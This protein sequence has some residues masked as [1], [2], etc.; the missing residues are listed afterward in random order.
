MSQPP[1]VSII[2]AMSAMLEQTLRDAQTYDNPYQARYTVDAVSVFARH[3][4]AIVNEDERLEAARP[5]LDRLIATGREASAAAPRICPECNEPHHDP[6]SLCRHCQS[7]S[8]WQ[9]S[10]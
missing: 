8:D 1:E 10:D 7:E 3:I 6:G 4:I 2:D 9:D 5:S